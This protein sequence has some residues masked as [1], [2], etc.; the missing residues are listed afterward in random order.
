MRVPEL[1]AGAS[2]ALVGFTT[3]A[4]AAVLGCNVQGTHP[5]ALVP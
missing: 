4:A 1:E 2:L 3:V 5:D